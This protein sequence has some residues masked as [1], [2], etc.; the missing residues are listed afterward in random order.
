MCTPMKS[1]GPLSRRTWSVGLTLTV[2]IAALVGMVWTDAGRGPAAGNADSEAIGGSRTL[3]WIDRQG[4]RS[5]LP[6]PARGY[7]YPRIAPDGARI[8]LDIR[9]RAHGIWIWQ[10]AEQQ[11]TPFSIGRASDIAPVWTSDGRAIVFARGRAVA[12][13]ILRKA[14][15]GRGEVETLPAATNGLLMPTSLSP[16]SA[17]LVVTASVATGFDLQVLGLAGRG[18]PEP[19]VSTAFDEL[20]GEVSPD[21][22]WLA[23][24]SRQSGQF[25]IWVRHFDPPAA[26]SRREPVAPAAPERRSRQSPDPGASAW[27][28]SD[29]GGTRP[30]WA[31]NGRELFYLTVDNQMMT[32]PIA[33]GEDFASG[34]PIE[35][36]A[37]PIYADLVGRTFDVSPDGQRFLVVMG[38]MRTQ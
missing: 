21:G 13:A 3:V 24:Q 23:Y 9:D 30:V 27:Q 11:L 8:A 18:T 15:D 26:S 34:P 17:A 38:L 33:A 16:D 29:H 10:I 35:L 22:R 19:L 14:S 5:P 32:V 2:S 7:V 37:A 4:H 1:A 36:F 31:R 28:V 6:V 25:E 12:P 20:N